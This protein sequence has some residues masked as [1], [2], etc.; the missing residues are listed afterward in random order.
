MVA[1]MNYDLCPAVTLATIV[2]QARAAALWLFRRHGRRLLAI[3]LTGFEKSLSRHSWRQPS[4]TAKHYLTRLEAWGYTLS[5]VE[6]RR[7]RR[8]HHTTDVAGAPGLGRRQRRHEG[9]RVE[10]PVGMMDRRPH[11]GAAAL[12]HEDVLDFG[13]RQECR[14]AL[15]PQVDDLADLRHAQRPERAVVHRGV[16]DHLRSADRRCRCRHCIAQGVQG[17]VVVGCF[18]ADADRSGL[19]RFTVTAGAA[20]AE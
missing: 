7:D 6:L 8:A 14:G 18:V 13:T 11:L 12:E 19:A 2:G 17:A 20:G 15:G 4:P 1:V 10:L 16:E 9:E 3:V 5:D